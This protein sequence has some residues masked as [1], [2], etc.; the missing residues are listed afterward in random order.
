MFHLALFISKLVKFIIKNLGFG[1][2]YTWPGHVALKIY[3]KILSSSHIK[4]PKGLIL[5]SGTNGKT[6]TSKILSHLLESSGLTVTHNKTGA[7]MVNGIVS[8]ILLNMNF[9]GELSSDVG[10]FEVDEGNLP[11][12]L[13]YLH[14]DV[15]ILL[16]LSRDQL[17]RYGEVDIIFNNWKKAIS[18]LNTDTAVILDKEQKRF[19]EV[20]NIF[21]GRIFYFD[22]DR[23]YLN[24]TRLHG[25]FNAKNV[26][27]AFL[28][29]VLVGVEEHSIDGY[30]DNFEAAYGRG[31]L[32]EHK[33]KSF[34]VL[35][36][37]NPA[38]FNNNLGALIND[39]RDSDTY[40]FVLNDNIP[41]GRDTSWIYDINPERLKKVC[42][43]KEIF[44]SGSRFLDMAIRL[45]YAGVSVKEMYISD[46]LVAVIDT[47]VR[48]E[49]TDDIVVL[50]NYSA[51]LEVRNILVGRAI[52]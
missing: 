3:P 4:F 39:I 41:D 8:T 1:S 36:A 35:L 33:G 50:P 18:N 29:S 16:N 30:L 37:K 13:G 52:L 20:Q 43:D 28:A 15:L 24:R 31:E 32:V 12:V 7:N 40:L 19:H 46:N 2:G 5:I 45:R 27:A 23:T 49:N 21:S 14:P 26:N 9:L 22:S 25:D 38:S 10:V 47:I 51:M 34:Q 42:G 48:R 17:D 6:T 44:V 11:K